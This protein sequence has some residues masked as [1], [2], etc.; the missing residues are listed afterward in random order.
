[1]GAVGSNVVLSETLIGGADVRV[2]VRVNDEQDE[3]PYQ[4]AYDHDEMREERASSGVLLNKYTKVML[5]VKSDNLL[6]SSTIN[7]HKPFGNT[8]VKNP[9][10]GTASDHRYTFLTPGAKYFFDFGQWKR[11]LWRGFQQCNEQV[12]GQ[13]LLAGW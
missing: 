5:N 10:G 7:S 13:H 6:P 1:V 8:S 4:L 2:F 12:R 9:N 3:C 11:I